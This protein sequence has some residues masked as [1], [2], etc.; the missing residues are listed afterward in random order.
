MLD[1]YIYN[2]SHIM[3]Y[4]SALKINEILPFPAIWEDL[5]NNTLSEVRQRKTNESKNSTNESIFKKQNKSH[6]HRKQTYGYQR[7]RGR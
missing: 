1:I 2:I 4:Y 6:R 3:R 7:V 5:E